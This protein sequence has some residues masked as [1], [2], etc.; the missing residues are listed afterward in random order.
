[1]NTENHENELLYDANATPDHMLLT[2]DDPDT[3]NEPIYFNSTPKFDVSQVEQC[4]RKQN[5]LIST[6]SQPILRPKND[7]IDLDD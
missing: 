4:E 5:H 6:I 7:E 1:M 2:I 3:V